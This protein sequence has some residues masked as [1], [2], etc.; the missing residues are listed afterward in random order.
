M[1]F[2]RN[3]PDSEIIR[4]LLRYA[5]PYW[6]DFIIVFVVMVMVWSAFRLVEGVDSLNNYNVIADWCYRLERTKPQLSSACIGYEIVPHLAASIHEFCVRS[7]I[8]DGWTYGVEFDS[9][10]KTDPT[11]LPYEELN[12]AE[13]KEE[14]MNVI[15]DEQRRILEAWQHRPS[16]WNK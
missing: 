4:R 3:M 5:R 15:N 8:D 10:R 6:K 7:K 13:R 2:E 1:G 14:N 12:E 11:L 9:E 16:N